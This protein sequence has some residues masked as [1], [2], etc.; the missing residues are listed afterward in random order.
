MKNKEN[1]GM[2]C[3]AHRGASGHEPENT[4]RAFRTALNLGAPWIEI[5]IQAVEGELVVIHDDTLGRTTSGKGYVSG[6]NLEYLRALDAGKG[7]R[8]PLLREVLDL[9][10]KAGAGINIELKGRDT[11]VLA[12]SLIKEYVGKGCLTYDQII[13]S[14]FS[15]EELKKARELSPELKIGL[16][17]DK[18]TPDYYQTAEALCAFSLHL[19]FRNIDQKLVE[20]AHSL[21]L[22][23]IAFTVNKPG[24]IERMRR[25]GVD[26]IFT[27]Y[28]E[29]MTNGLKKQTLEKG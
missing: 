19:N 8:I 28:P 14:S 10:S 29:L 13:V 9:I 1:K 23:V 15:F 7:E 27:D 5:D 16:L 4:L 2:V 21:G 17:Y 3:F 6:Q 18:L 24:D 26:G 20:E 25:L 11:A 12:V 22:M